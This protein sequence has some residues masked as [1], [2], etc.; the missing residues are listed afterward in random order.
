MQSPFMPGLHPPDSSTWDYLKSL[1]FASKGVFLS[2]RFVLGVLCKTESLSFSPV[3]QT[4]W[5]WK[6]QRFPLRFGVVV[7]K[8]FRSKKE[9]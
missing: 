7:K 4:E 6:A 3:L 8:I 5:R 1:A 2:R 9:V